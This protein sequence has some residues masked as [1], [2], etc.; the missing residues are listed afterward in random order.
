MQPQY[1]YRFGKVEV[2]EAR[3]QVTV[4]GLPVEIEQR[5][6]QL[7]L[8]LLRNADEAVTKET[9][10]SRVWDRPTVENVLANAIA[11]L[12]RALGPEEGERLITLP[13][14]GYRLAGPI[15][16]TAVGRQLSSRLDLQAGAALP[17]RPN[18][19]L[20]R[21]LAA[22]DSH[23]V[24]LAR[25]SRT[26]E[27]RVYKFANNGA[28]L[29][30]LKREATLFRLMAESLPDR[31]SL[32]RILDWNFET[33]PW[34]LESEYG[35][36]NLA[37]W[38]RQ[39]DRLRQLTQAQRLTLFQQIVGAVAAAHGV[40]VLHKDIKPANLLITDGE[41]GPAVRICDFGAGH[42]LEPDRLDDLGITRMGLTLG[43]GAGTTGTPLYMAPELLSGGAPT[44]RSDVY[45]LGLLLY[46]L[47]AGDLTRPLA[48]GWEQD[49][50][51]ELLREDI[52]AATQVDP[53]KRLG[54]AGELQS[55]LLGLLQRHADR[56]ASRAAAAAASAA[57]R[58]WERSRA[59][60][61]WVFAAIASL[62]GLLALSTWFYVAS[63][64]TAQ[65]LARQ[66]RTTEAVNRFMINELIGASSPTIS[67]RANVTLLEAAKAAAPRIDASFGNDAPQI[68]AALHAAMQEA[69]SDLTDAPA[70]IEEGNKAL[71]ALMSLSRPDP[72]LV[73][74]VRLRMTRDLAR[75]GDFD[76]MSTLLQDVGRDL[77]ALTA[78]HPT[79]Q[80][81]YL[82]ARSVLAANKLQVS[83][84]L[85]LDSEAW[86][87]LQSLPN[88]PDELR[89]RLQFSV[90][91]GLW[92]TG[93]VRESEQLLRGLIARQ[94]ARLG[95]RHQ[96]TL[97]TTVMLAHTLLLQQRWD[98]ARALLPAA[99]SGLDQ[100]LGADHGRSLLA[101][102][103]LGQTYLSAG[104]YPEA[105]ATFTQ[106]HDAQARKFGDKYQGTISTLAMIGVAQYQAG[107]V[108]AAEG[109]LRT[110]LEQARQSGG[111]TDPS[112]QNFRYHLALCLMAQHRATEAA[113]LAA[114]LDP[115]TL[116]P[117]E[118]TDDWP[119][120]LA[121]LDARIALERGDRSAASRHLE[122][123][124]GALKE[125]TKWR[126]DKL[127]EQI[128]MLSKQF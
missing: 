50:N 123:A 15:E 30:Q 81:E 31:S 36:L 74:R 43:Q 5:P 68:R 55:R 45:A 94:Q 116:G 18:F 59:R 115:V 114:G 9:L 103:V 48:S 28:A 22:S 3:L 84:S 12:R 127:P 64:A 70:A 6:L 117:A 44:V 57:A 72:V 85:Q 100:A 95:P 42:I 93:R 13:R 96:Q 40:G 106:V 121:L 1:R 90:A 110:A 99:I 49:V 62:S 88:A 122:T 112:V 98:E 19:V 76:R 17:L 39:D 69:L 65:Q 21:Q 46:Q 20:E 101:R 86:T 25:H 128:A 113:A 78:Q 33:A 108:Q 41:S 82:M 8:E 89:D 54:S 118:Q 80:V 37:E 23:E 63:R 32:V 71:T 87:L 7:L 125:P 38:S 2:D 109:S 47:L 91:D 126:L 53:A 10:L 77:P 24:W 120:R 67:G 124:R 58:Q 79:L 56:Q 66:A 52:A 102:R 111:D 11:K 104:Q 60:R 83:Q 16:R 14:I 105:I 35:G 97:Y 75:V 4:G 26:H 29:S 119:S 61:P 92:M 34:F 51:D 107:R 27:P 73:T